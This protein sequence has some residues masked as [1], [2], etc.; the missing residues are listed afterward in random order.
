M[1]AALSAGRLSRLPS[2]AALR[3]SVHTGRGALRGTRLALLTIIV[4]VLLLAGHAAN[5]TLQYGLALGVI[6]GIAILGSNVVLATLGEVNLATGASMA[7]GA[8]SF[9]WFDSH[10]VPVLPSILLAGV[11]AGVIGAVLAVPTI[12]LTGVFT[13]LVTFALAFAVP[14]L[15]IELKPLTGGQAGIAPALGGTV[16]GLDPS[17]A[18]DMLTL[19][20]VVFLVLAGVLTW[21]FH[22]RIGRTAVAVGESVRAA[23]SFGVRRSS[24]AIGVW[25]ASAVIC[26]VGGALL[27]I[28]VGFVTP[29]VF[30][31][32]LSITILV[33]SFAG[34]V[35]NASGAL[36]G[37]LLVGTVPPEIQSVIPAS[38]TSLALGVVLLLVL[39]TGGGGLGGVLERL[40]LA[41][42]SL[43]RRAR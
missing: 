15:I 23:E 20:C 17:N 1:T 14:D 43:L 40:G 39:V 27:A 6:Y 3:V 28:L 2:V 42:L 33:G 22:G 31:V 38:A 26:G 35:R 9:T 8:Y 24:W 36:F 10:S 4:A 32:L 37:G 41:S 18:A 29:S 16:L 11:V 21:L 13:A 25:T 12:R 30:P 34:G 7:V 5:S 19:A